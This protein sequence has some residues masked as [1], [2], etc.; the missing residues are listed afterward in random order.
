MKDNLFLDFLNQIMKDISI[1][2]SENIDIFFLK[3]KY[4]TNTKP[5]A[6]FLI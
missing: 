4:V 1:Y 5:S 3:G 6:T 2:I